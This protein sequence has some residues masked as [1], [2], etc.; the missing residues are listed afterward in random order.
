MVHTVPEIAKL[1]KRCSDYVNAS[2]NASVRGV[3]E[4]DIIHGTMT[5]DFMLSHRPHD[6]TM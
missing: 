4:A 1:S 2:F 6:D 3:G 5:F